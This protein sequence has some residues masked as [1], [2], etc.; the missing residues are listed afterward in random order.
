MKKS[1][2]KLLLLLYSPDLYSPQYFAVK[3][4]SWVLPDLS[5]S[6]RRSLLYWLEQKGLI[7][8]LRRSGGLQVSLTELGKQQ[9]EL[10]LPA[11][12][13]PSDIKAEWHLMLFK[14][15]PTSDPNFHF[16]RALALKNGALPVGRGIYAFFSK[17][18]AIVLETCRTKY[19]TAVAIGGVSNWEVGNLRDVAVAHYRL[20]DL[21]HLYSGVSKEISELLIRKYAEKE[22]ND[23]SNIINFSL[24]SRFF[25]NVCE[26]SGLVQ[27]F[28]PHTPRVGDILRDFQTLLL[29]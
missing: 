22:L 14:T 19:A 11:L 3:Q 7:H 16:L 10:E 1:T 28:F 23:R 12:Q 29:T 27:Y 25:A 26:D 15:A 5:D 4:L 17:V 9:L 13:S 20:L 24:Y 8:S 18:P 21:S 2:K 6:G